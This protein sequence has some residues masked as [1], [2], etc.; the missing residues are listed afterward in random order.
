L[1]EDDHLTRVDAAHFSAAEMRLFESPPGPLLFE[2]RTDSP[3]WRA[4][5]QAATPHYQAEVFVR[6][7]VARTGVQETISVH[8]KPE[9]SAVGSLLVRLA[10]RPSGDVKWRLGGE[11]TRELPA[12]LESHPPATGSSDAAVYRLLLPRP[13]SSAF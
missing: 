9:S 5:L 1:V 7:D 12:V 11:D 3:A 6:A 13:Q 2:R 4:K 8:C 10:P